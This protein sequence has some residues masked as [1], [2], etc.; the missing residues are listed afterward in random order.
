MVLIISEIGIRHKDM[1]GNLSWNHITSKR[2]DSLRVTRDRNCGQFKFCMQKIGGRLKLVMITVGFMVDK[3]IVSGIY[4]PTSA[5]GNQNNSRNC[6][7]TKLHFFCCTPW[8]WQI[9]TLQLRMCQL[10]SCIPHAST[11]TVEA[12]TSD[13]T[14]LRPWKHKFL[15]YC[16]IMLYQSFSYGIFLNDTSPNDGKIRII[17]NMFIRPLRHYGHHQDLHPTRSWMMLDGIS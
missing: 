10:H 13:G 2:L 5:W 9:K 16:F 14:F 8:N 4:I 17:I 7:A 1:I 15:D 6:W 3:C 12:H 11:S